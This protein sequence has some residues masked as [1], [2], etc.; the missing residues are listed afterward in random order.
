MHR[1]VPHSEI[2][3]D[4][5]AP[6]ARPSLRVEDAPLLR[7]RGRFVD[8]IAL[9]GLLHA[10]FVRSP[11]AHARLNGID[12]SAARALPG[13][14]AVL[15]YRDLRPVI[16]HDRIPLALPVAAIRQ[17]V[18]PSWLVEKEMCFVGEPV[19]V[20]IAENR[21]TAE[22]AA[23]LVV[24][25]YEELPA[26][27][28]PVAALVAGAPKARLDCADNLVAQWELKYGDAERAF[29]GA[30]HRIAQRFRIHKGGG[31]SIET[32]AVLARYDEAEDLLTVWDGTQ[33]PHK[34]KRVIVDTLGLVE[35]QVRVIAPNVGGGFGPKNPFYPE[36]LVVPAV[37]RLLGAPVK[38]IE[39]RRESFT[40]TNH[41]REQDW[42]L[43]A[44]IDAD[45]KLLAVR[46]KV[47]HDHGSATPSG[48]STAQ[49]SA[50]NFIGPYVL[51]A[52]N[53]AFVVC[54]TNFTPATSSRGAGRPQG[55]YVME[56]LLDRIAERLSLP[57]D[58]VRRR[59]LIGPD[60]MPY[61]TEVVTRDGLPMTY[62]SGDYPES[63]RRALETARWSDF[64]ARQEAA[65]RKGRF[66]GL[67]LSNYVEGTGR[68]PFES[69]SVRIGP[70][71]KIVVAT[72][73]TD[74]GQGTHT[75]LAQLAAEAFG[76][77]ADRVQVVAGDTAASPLGHGAYAS[78]QAVTAGN[79]L[80]IASCL[81][82]DKAKQVASAMLEVSTDDLELADG[83][84]RVR[85]VPG[86]KKSL[87]EIA[88][89][90]SG[91]AGF[92]L[93][94]GETP[95]L[96]ASNDFI[97]PAITYTNGTHVCEVEI[98]PDTGHIRLLRY[99]VVHDC[100]R[101]ISPMMVEGQVHGAV[102]HG[103]GATLYEWMRYDASGQ[104]QTVTL[105]DYMLPTSDTMPPIEIHHM[106]SPT[107]LNPLGVKGAAESGTIGA[108][109]A[110]VSAIEDALKPLGVR[111]NDLPVTPERLLALIQSAQR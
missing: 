52:I 60:Q 34:A 90:L 33:M 48:L 59:N 70:S 66:I 54:L 17:H 94:A 77:T 19:A 85:G 36:E 92:S 7:G 58:E 25:D 79:A 14:R 69:V 37:A 29:A 96:A 101:M 43:E 41:E 15:T 27:T 30:A 103:V 63:Q 57:R 18:D 49:N 65:R 68:G 87:G 8:D 55:T 91:V 9:P 32:R 67:G 23:N 105:A 50:T 46:G 93:P 21:A 26:V 106:E 53:I 99:I 82:A 13:V 86:M 64:P 51:P 83:E 3:G 71:G 16:G 95:G 47:H 11:V 5:H 107:P 10:S 110:I 31:H 22:D 97:P 100:G 109:A 24:L 102:A 42:D 104:P 20:V 38:W 76:V 40:A 88:H 4:T 56:R 108:P 73:A 45:G 62:D 2:S 39:D 12:A 84:V 28:D 44:A 6:L 72:G 80:H 75:M 81:V 61:V 1:Y 78:R 35:S 74:Q 89:A 111:I 98:D